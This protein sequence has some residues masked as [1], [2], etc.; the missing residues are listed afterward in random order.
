MQRM[1]LQL[2]R[3]KILHSENMSFRIQVLFFIYKYINELDDKSA[4]IFAKLSI[5]HI[6]YYTHKHIKNVW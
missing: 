5:Y 3:H 2:P 1:D 6:L 4:I